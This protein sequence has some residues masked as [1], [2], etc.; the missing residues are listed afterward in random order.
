M[1]DPIATAI[2]ICTTHGKIDA[3]YILK[4]AAITR[5]KIARTM[6][7]RHE[8]HGEEKQ[9][10]PRGQHATRNISD[11]LSAVAHRYDERSEIVHRTDQNR[12]KQHPQ[13]CRQ[14]AP[15]YRQRRPTIGPVPAIEVK[16]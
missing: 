8:Q 4:T 2:G 11:R 16:W 3:G 10:R 7:K 6:V 9:A 15:D 5:P 13:Q 14:P 1:R 12:A